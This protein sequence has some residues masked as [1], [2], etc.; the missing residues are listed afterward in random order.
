MLKQIVSVS[1]LSIAAITLPATSLAI[2]VQEVPNPRQVN[3]GWV[4]D[5]ANILSPATEARLNQM[6]SQ[7]E[8]EN[9]S[10]IAVVTV[11]ETAPSATPKEFAT[12]LFNYW[13]I[14]KAGVD[15]GVLLLISTGDRRVEIETGYG[16]EGI[17]PDARVGSI[18]QNKIT[19]RFK[20]GDF[21]G[22]TLAGT[23]ALV[24]A[25]KTDALP[26]N[27]GVINAPTLNPGVEAPSLGAGEMPVGWLGGIGAGGALLA[28]IGYRLSRRRPVFVEPE[29]Y[30]RSH[31]F[32]RLRRPLHCDRCKQPMTKLDS[33]SLM[34]YLSQP[35]QVAQKIGSIEFEGWQ[36]PNCRPHLT[37]L[38]MHIHAYV[39]NSSQF[40]RCPKCQERTVTKMSSVL[41]HPTQYSEGR[42]LTTYNCH[43]CDY[44]KQTEEWI[45]R[46]PPP[47][48]PP[49][50]SS[51]GG[52]SG[53]GGFGGGGGFS[54]GGGSFGGGSS[55]GGGA[56]GGW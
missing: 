48:P 30:F 29:G 27:P 11:P 41:S 47:P 26:P 46:L 14:G 18:I 21:E 5:Q 34:L 50:S 39:S 19:P 53:S 45:P 49:S 42:R 32:W 3:G 4:T 15:N 44:H 12:N 8:T 22:G 31:N 38:G 24:V 37:G 1:V 20:Q 35:Q 10:E 40:N 16:V 56:G 23:E 54:G 55:G 28:F 7:L 52:S 36:C 6:I 9:G 51:G 17:L 25:L 33:S 2:S 13:K 43:C